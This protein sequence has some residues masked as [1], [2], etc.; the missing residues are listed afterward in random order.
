[1]ASL[2][3]D[4][5]A[6]RHRTTVGTDRRRS[7]ARAERRRAGSRPL[8]GALL[9]E[10]IRA[11][12]CSSRTAPPAGRS[13]RTRAPARRRPPT[14]SRPASTSA[15]SSSR[16]PPRASSTRADVKVAVET[17]A[18]VRGEPLDAARFDLYRAVCSS[19]FL[20]EL[21]PL[22]ASEIQLRLL[23]Q[24]GDR[25]R[26]LTL[27]QRRRQRRACSSRSGHGAGSRRARATAKAALRRG[28]TLSL[29]GPQTLRA[30]LVRRFRTPVRRG[31]RARARARGRADAYL[32]TAGAALSPILER[33][34]LLERSHRARADPRPLRASSA[35][36]GS[37]S[38]STTARSRT[39]SPSARRSRCCATRSTRS[40]SRATASAPP[41]RFDDML[42]PRRRARPAAARALP[43]PRVAQ[44]RH[45]PARRDPP[46]RG[47]RV[48]R[49]HRDHDAARDPRRSGVDH[50]APSGSP[51][52]GRSRSRSRT[53]ASTPA[54][55]P[56]RSGSGCAAR[57][58][59]SAS[60][61]DGHGFEVGRALARAA[62]RGRL[63]IVGIGERV[64][65]L[66]GTF[67]I[68][69]AP[70][71]P[72]ILTFA[73]PRVAPD[74]RLV[75]PLERAPTR[76]PRRRARSLA[77]RSTRSWQ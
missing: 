30:G 5:R 3:R 8:T 41:A 31:R 29:L 28:S 67:E 35:S 15:T 75:L 11:S 76:G 4:R 37:A 71:G 43:L 46:P 56:S 47:R 48:R 33:E 58:S 57:R 60:R 77:I 39:F 55:R 22:V 6:G 40:S 63:G 62:Q 1:M 52:T 19:P 10:R 26:G 54:P 7:R 45:A 16:S 49:A 70:G 20:L 64:R 25:D 23:L 65:M 74:E 73:L 18:E 32:A 51:S 44:H 14:G 38:T 50:V 69:S 68:D 24:L 36:C 61:D 72:T 21:P 9:A 66:G 17:L 42:A 27:A 13:S 53:S 2:V 59:R 12:T 34:L